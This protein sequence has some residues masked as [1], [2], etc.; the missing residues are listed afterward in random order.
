MPII[1]T[2]SAWPSAPQRFT[3]AD[4]RLL[5]I[6]DPDRCGVRLMVT[7]AG[8][9]QV[10][11]L[12]DGELIYSGDPMRTPGGAGI[13]YDG[14][15]PLDGDVVYAAGMADGTVIASVAVHTAGLPAEW[16]L[17]TPLDDQALAVRLRTVASTPTLKRA[18]RQKLSLSPA[19][20]LNAGGWDLP[21]EDGQDWTW[22]CGLIDQ[23]DAIG[24]RD[25][26]MAALTC[27]PVYWR[28]EASI[29]FSSMWALPGDV[30]A[31][32]QGD[33]WLVSSTLTPVRPP[34]TLDLPAWAPGYTYA[35]LLKRGTFADVL[36]GA[37]NYSSLVGF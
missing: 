7:D 23:S 24:E 5:A 27:G 31:T 20:T 17:V 26:L 11:L 16:G 33:V 28:P 35:D 2:L 9:D 12:R 4:G 10:Q 1:N 3:S 29:G 37:T 19:S 30:E 22:L 14:L 6:L 8:T 15:A 21:A 32:R 25:R 34:S 13:A 36:A 18:A